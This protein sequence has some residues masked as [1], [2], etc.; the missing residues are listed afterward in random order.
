MIFQYIRDFIRDESVHKYEILEEDH[1]EG[2]LFS[3]KEM[4]VL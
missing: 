4:G 1:G 2:V 3:V